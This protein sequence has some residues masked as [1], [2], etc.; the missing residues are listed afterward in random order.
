MT[1]TKFADFLKQRIPVVGT[2][3]TINL[4]SGK[5][6]TSQA[7]AV[8]R[9]SGKPDGISL[10]AADILNRLFSEALLK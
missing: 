8:A 4:T 6:T 3:Y 7:G 10:Q 2:V 9:H 5:D 1:I